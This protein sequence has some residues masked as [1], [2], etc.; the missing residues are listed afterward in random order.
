[1]KG[2]TSEEQQPLCVSVTALLKWGGGEDAPLKS[3]QGILN[4]SRAVRLSDGMFPYH[5]SFSLFFSQCI[6]PHISIPRR[7][8]AEGAGI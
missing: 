5:L 2:D 4:I 7:K 1:M 8:C 3:I 6:C